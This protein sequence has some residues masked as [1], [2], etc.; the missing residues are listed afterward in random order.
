MKNLSYLLILVITTLSIHL[1]AQTAAKGYI[2]KVNRDTV[3]GFILDKTDTDLSPGIIFKTGKK[4]KTTTH[5]TTAD[6]LGFGFDYGR[7]FERMVYTDSLND[8]V[9]IFAKRVLQG[10][11]NL[12]LWRKNAWTDFDI[13]LFN[14]DPARSVHLSEPVK[15]VIKEED[16]IQQ[17]IYKYNHVGLLKY[18][19][20]DTSRIDGK[21]KR[22][23]YSEK[24][25]IDDIQHYNLGYLGKYPVKK[26]RDKKRVFFDLAIGTAVIKAPEGLNLRGSIYVNRFAPEKNRN[27]SLLAGVTYRYWKSSAAV[28]NLAV[29]DNQNYQQQMISAIPIGVNFHSAS[30][31]FRPYIYCG[32]GLAVLLNTNY[33]F[34]KGESMGS[35]TEILLLPGVNIGAGVKIRIGTQFIAVEITPT[36]NGSGVFANLGYSF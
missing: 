36:G 34:V 9:K 3:H 14:R 11:I 32:I 1:R 10:K 24:K 28:D 5:Y 33:R 35:K 6:L 26:Y 2:V 13:F 16:G 12:F 31:I 20:G 17:T 8:T 27:F 7:A 29:N 21:V 19:K 30:G 15:K 18:V 23:R 22:I 25:I 4:E